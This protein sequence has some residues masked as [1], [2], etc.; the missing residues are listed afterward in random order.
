MY[1]FVFIKNQ[2][3]KMTAKDEKRKKINE[4]R[5]SNQISFVIP[6][7]DDDFRDKLEFIKTYDSGKTHKDIY[8]KGLDAL[9][10]EMK[11]NPTPLDFK[12]KELEAIIDSKEKEL[13]KDKIQL[14]DYR[15]Q[16]NE[17][18]KEKD[19]RKEK[20]FVNELQKDYTSYKRKHPDKHI[21]DFV[22]TYYRTID[23]RYVKSNYHNKNL[24]DHQICF[25]E[26]DRINEYVKIFMK[27]LS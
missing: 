11:G 9:Y 2:E 17:I 19:F 10:N 5:K 24:D 12:I 14:D 20:N 13:S 26:D 23:N 7:N 25:D 21:R 4:Y 27:H 22:K 1:S 8:K 15:K 16:K 18:K 6:K 3:V